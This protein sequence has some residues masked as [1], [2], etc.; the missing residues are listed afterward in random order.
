MHES[1]QGKTVINDVRS[2][3]VCNNSIIP[4]AQSKHKNPLSVAEKTEIEKYKAKL[5]FFYA[6]SHTLCVRCQLAFS[7]H[8]SRGPI[9][10][11][12]LDDFFEDVKRRTG[13]VFVRTEFYFQ[14]FKA[15]VSLFSSAL[16]SPGRFYERNI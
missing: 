11:S 5:L 12:F 13:R 1:F 16:L 10:F 2:T 15:V 6:K 8:G 14:F 3:D 9:T 7:L 4:L